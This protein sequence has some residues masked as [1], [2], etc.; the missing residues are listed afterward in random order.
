MEAILKIDDLNEMFKEKQIKLS[1]DI[2]ISLKNIVEKSILITVDNNVI[3]E[4]ENLAL[5]QIMKYLLENEIL[6][7]N[8]YLIL[9][10]ELLHFCSAFVSTIYIAKMGLNCNIVIYSPD[11]CDKTYELIHLMYSVH[12]A[13]DTI[14]FFSLITYDDYSQKKWIAN[15]DQGYHDIIDKKYKISD[16]NLPLLPINTKNVESFFNTQVKIYL[17]KMTLPH[18]SYNNILKFFYKNFKSFNK[19]TKTLNYYCLHYY[20]LINKFYISNKYDYWIFLDE[21]LISKIETLP[22]I[23]ILILNIL[24]DE[25]ELKE[26]IVSYYNEHFVIKDSESKKN[27]TDNIYQTF[28][29]NQ[30]DKENNFFQLY[31]DS[32]INFTNQFTKGIYELA[33]NVVEHST[34]NRGLL[35]VRKTY[36]S[37]ILVNKNED[38]TIWDNYFDSIKNQD[39]QYIYKEKKIQK[40][41]LDISIIDDGNKGIIEKSI[42]DLTD[43][44]VN[45]LYKE[46]RADIPIDIKVKDLETIEKGLKKQA[47]LMYNMY[48]NP[49]DII[50]ARQSN[51]S[52]SS[53]GLFIFT[54][55]IHSYQGIFNVN[56]LVHNL[57]KFGQTFSTNSD[58]VS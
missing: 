33:K 28:I 44:N 27:H 3:G 1:N 53:Y 5:N 34:N 15:A 21:T 22:M 35:T 20:K 24:I 47:D 39:F 8:L 11:N 30:H 37:E 4:M 49:N 58:K 10:K 51:L 41:F 13:P 45:R 26:R 32:L 54:K 16:K 29:K 55:F 23:S 17:N 46:K 25:D 40:L 2:K 7:E 9:P 52:L 38:K 36:E 12:L 42:D 6:L 31:I 48:F 14:N 43:Q 50:L 19:K 57:T 18:E 56:S